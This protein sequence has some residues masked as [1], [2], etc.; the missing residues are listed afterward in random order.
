MKNQTKTPP[1]DEPMT[2]LSPCS[3]V[4]RAPFMQL[5]EDGTAGR[6]LAQNGQTSGRDAHVRAEH[7]GRFPTNLEKTRTLRSRQRPA[8]SCVAWARL[9]S[10]TA[11]VAAVTVIPT[12]CGTTCEEIRAS[13]DRFQ[14]QTQRSEKPHAV[15][16]VPF[17]LANRLI[18]ERLDRRASAEVEIAVLQRFGLKPPIR[19]D[20]LDTRLVAAEPGKAGIVATIGVRHATTELLTL[21]LAVAVEPR[22]DLGQRMVEIAVRAEDF[23]RVT[24]RLGP[25]G[26]DGIVHWLSDMLPPAVRLMVPDAALGELADVV[27]GWVIEAGFPLVRDAVLAPLDVGTEFSWALPALPITAVSLR[28]TEGA[29]PALHALIQTSLPVATGLDASLPSPPEHRIALYLAGDTV[30]AA[31]NRAISEGLLPR[32]FSR[33]GKPDPQ[34]PLEAGLSWGPAPRPLKIHLWQTRG[35][36]IYTRIGGA[37]AATLIDGAETVQVDVQDGVYESVRGPASLEATSWLAPLFADAIEASLEVGRSAEFDLA[38]GPLRVAVDG[39]IVGASTVR[40]ELAVTQ[41]ETEPAPQ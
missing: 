5:L 38:G 24:P 2:H 32:R 20:L 4:R 41:P 12:G 34:G 11:L 19:F 29:V 22:L 14:T 17:G 30:A 28:S 36:C 15:L 25:G 31:A 26:K 8:L 39:I 35:E 27:L 3:E 9:L 18:R 33:A 21:E 23:S 16:S 13:R 7:R 1:K 6:R 40:F 37:V 10:L